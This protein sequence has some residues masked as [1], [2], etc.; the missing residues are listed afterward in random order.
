MLKVFYLNASIVTM[1]NVMVAASF[2]RRLS[3]LFLI[4]KGDWQT[5]NEKEGAK[6]LHC[7]DQNPDVK[8]PVKPCCLNLNL[9]NH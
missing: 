3:F 8:A 5:G 1:F 9:P 6:E 2:P 7:T 4:A